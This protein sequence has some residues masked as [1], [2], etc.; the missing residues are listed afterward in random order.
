[1]VRDMIIFMNVVNMSKDKMKIIEIN[2]NKFS[3]L[4]LILAI[5]SFW[6]AVFTLG[7]S[8]EQQKVIMYQLKTRIEELPDDSAKRKYLENVL[9]EIK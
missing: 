1:M 8:C 6:I 3:I 5:I 7:R 4:A 9:E 2:M